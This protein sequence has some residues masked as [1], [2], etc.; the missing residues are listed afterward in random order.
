MIKAMRKVV[1]ERLRHPIVHWHIP[2]GQS[3]PPPAWRTS[4]L[5]LLVTDRLWPVPPVGGEAR[6]R[7]F[8]ASQ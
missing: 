3:G 6:K 7:P 5:P 4:P 8:A 2:L 1:I